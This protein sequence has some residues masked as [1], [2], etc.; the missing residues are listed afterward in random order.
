MRTQS[1]IHPGTRYRL[2]NTSI[3]AV[4]KT[5]A[6]R[7]IASTA[8]QNARVATKSASRSMA[9]GSAS[10]PAV[11]AATSPKRSGHTARLNWRT[12]TVSTTQPA[13]SAASVAAIATAVVPSIS[14]PNG[15]SAAR[16][17]ATPGSRLRCST[18]P[19]MSTNLS[20]FCV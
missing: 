8:N 15:D 20:G 10:R 16:R 19:V 3:T 14:A 4:V 2:P 18:T 13:T 7:L 1:A 17:A 5:N 6:T 11:G 12:D 9:S